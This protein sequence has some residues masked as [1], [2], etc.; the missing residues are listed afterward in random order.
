MAEDRHKQAKYNN[1]TIEFWDEYIYNNTDTNTTEVKNHIYLVNNKILNSVTQILEKYDLASEYPDTDNVRMA[2]ERGTFVH[3]ECE[4]VFLNDKYMPFSAEAIWVKNNLKPII[5][6]PKTE[7]LL[8]TEF[9]AGQCDLFGE[10]PTG[11][12][13]I[14]DYKTYKPNLETVSWQL[15]MY[16]YGLVH[17]GLIDP[18]KPVTFYVAILKDTVEECQLVE[19]EPIPLAEF[20]KLCN[21][22]ANEKRYIRPFLPISAT[23]QPTLEGKE[24]ID[25]ILTPWGKAKATDVYVFCK[26]QAS[27]V[28]EVEEFVKNQINGKSLKRGMTQDGC[29]WTL[30][31]R[32]DTRFDE[33]SFKLDHP[34]DYEKYRRSKSTVCLRWKGREEEKDKE[35]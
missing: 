18:K 34:E 19:V 14:L 10:T 6:N 33:A 12:Y 28:K 9:Y 25:T 26:Q 29:L 15:T 1:Q 2:A 24:E 22:I 4:K 5:V 23:L 11:S 21:C 31:H 7:T 3:S 16:Y 20:E 27:W 32:L 17:C 8:F 30:E 13:I 35:K